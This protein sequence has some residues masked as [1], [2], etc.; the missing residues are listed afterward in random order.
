MQS[1]I[2]VTQDE[3]LLFRGRVYSDKVDFRKAK[4]IEVEGELAYLNDS[5]VRPYHFK[6]AVSEYLQFLIMQHN[7]QVSENKQFTMGKVTVVDKNNLIV[8]ASSSY[9]KTWDEINEKLINLLGGY[10]MIR[11]QDEIN[12]LDYLEDFEETAGQQ[13]AYAVNLLELD[14]ETRMDDF[15]TCIIP[16]GAALEEEQ[17]NLTREEETGQTKRL[18][19]ETVNGGRDYIYDAAA[20]AVYGR[21]SKVVEWE[22]VTLPENL[23]KK[24][25]AYL[26]TSV[27]LTNALTVKAVDLHL[28][29][30]Q[31]AAFRIGQY[32]SVYSR[33]HNINEKMLLTELELQLDDPAGSTLMLGRE[34]KTF[35]GTQVNTAGGVSQAIQV[36]SSTQA[37][38][39]A[40]LQTA[41]KLQEDV[42]KK[43]DENQGVENKGKYLR[44][45]E[46]GNVVL[47]DVP[48]FNIHT[49][50]AAEELSEQAELVLYDPAAEMHKKVTLKEILSL[51]EGK[52][53]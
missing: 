53:V 11:R 32:V 22:D 13:I 10:L 25:Q 5:I 40:A 45:S 19:I 12:Y 46:N 29:D 30:T 28:T 1:I 4:T 37:S 50:Q 51:L 47:E 41:T 16:R 34:K 38:A 23:L 20:E 15:A 18:T 49:L 42:K 36:A 3:T 44:V 39:T 2:T 27:L 9:P 26:E 7:D 17:A 31:I 21:I 6:G 33:P 35:V 52:D 43:L 48:V 24:A 8:R 14:N